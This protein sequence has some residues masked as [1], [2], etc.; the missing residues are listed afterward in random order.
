MRLAHIVT[1]PIPYFT[2]LY[3]ELSS[4]PEVELTVFFASDISVQEYDDPAFGRSIAWDTPLLDG[5]PYRFMPSARGRKLVGN[6]MF[7]KPS[8]DI[9]R[10]AANGSFDAVWV[11]GYAYTNTWL[12]FAITRLRGKTFFVRD[13]PILLHSRSIWR[14]AIKYPIL[15]AVFRGAAGL[16][17]GEKNRRFLLHYGMPEERLFPARYCVDNAFFQSSAAKLA[18]QREALRGTFGVAG[19][20]PVVLFCGKFTAK[21]QPLGVIEAF[22]RLRERRRCRLLMVGEGELRPAAERL[23]A[24]RGVPDVV[25]AGFLNQS[26]IVRAYA[27]ADAFVLFS[28]DFETWGLVVNEAMNFALPIIVSDKVGCGEDLV[29][30]GENGYIVAHEDVD[31]LA[32]ALEAVLLSPERAAE[33]GARSREIVDE[34][35][36]E[37]CADGIVAACEALVRP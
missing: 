36:V 3:R 5:Y 13:E 21:K 6:R 30:E 1:H 22:A 19:D 26:E 31:G 12:S 24:R 16:Y 27:A 32:S 28:S 2:P 7:Y 29:H 20:D 9:I 4:R 8:F 15:W 25:F 23:V 10:A 18:P 11:H 17:I 35:S 34:Y 37:R 33:L 14:R